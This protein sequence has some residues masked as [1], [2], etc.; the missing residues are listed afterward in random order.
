VP[1][2]SQPATTTSSLQPQQPAVIAGSQINAAPAQLAPQAVPTI[3]PV[4]L[5]PSAVAGGQ[6]IAT[7]AT[8]PAQP[9]STIAK[10]A[11]ADIAATIAALAPE[12]NPAAVN[13]APEEKKQAFAQL[14]VKPA[15]QKT[16]PE[17]EKKPEPAKK[18][19]AAKKE[20]PA[21]K[22]Q[23]MKKAEAEK[24]ANSDKKPDQAKKTDT[25]KKAEPPKPKEPSRH[26]VQIAGGADK[27]AMDREFA[28]IKAKAPKLLGSR[29][30]W[31]TP[32]RFTNRL[33][34]GPFDST[35]EAQ[36]FVNELAKLDLSAF[37]WTSPAGQEIVKLS[38]K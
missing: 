18:P 14:D 9:D 1:G 23:D 7:P 24:K 29:T 37:S 31:T 13:T 38:A 21:K 20:E 10:P 22:P 17:P 35:E 36:E 6:P 26:W 25:A 15:P 34:V 33:L 2:F 11:F 5:P 12:T 27:A 8:V 19:A 30:P 28:R 16:A 3:A 4:E 32:L